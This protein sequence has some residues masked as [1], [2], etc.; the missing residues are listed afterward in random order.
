MRRLFIASCAL[1]AIIGMPLFLW[2]TETER[3]FAWTIRPPVTAAFMG[4]AYWASFVVV[5]L[6]LREKTWA[7]ARI[8]LWFAFAFAW[9]TMIATF[10]HLDRFHLGEQFAPAARIMTWTWLG[11]YVGVPLAQ[12]ALVIGLWRARGANPP[13]EQPIPGWYR[14]VSGAIGLLPLAIGSAVF[15]APAPVAATLWPW[16]LTPL[17]GRTVGAWLVAWGVVAGQIA[18]EADWRRVRPGLAGLAT[19]AVLELVVLAR[20]RDGLEWASGRPAAFVVGAA[21]LLVV[22]LGG[23]ALGRAAR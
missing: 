22:A 5:F 21:A 15:V 2:P 20:F 4:A 6:A 12:L 8:G 3:N 18:L 7:R 1:V 17:T 13:I 9:L 16:P 23:F 19:F 11:V 10:L 14:A